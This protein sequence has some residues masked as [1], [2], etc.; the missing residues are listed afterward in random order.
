MDSIGV[1]YCLIDNPPSPPWGKETTNC[2]FPRVTLPIIKKIRIKERYKSLIILSLLHVWQWQKVNNVVSLPHPI[3]ECPLFFFFFFLVVGGGG[4]ENRGLKVT[5]WQ[6]SRHPPNSINSVWQ[7][8]PEERWTINGVKLLEVCAEESNGDRG[9]TKWRRRRWRWR[10]RLGWGRGSRCSSFN[11]GEC[12]GR[13]CRRR[14]VEREKGE[15]LVLIDI[16]RDCNE[17]GEGMAP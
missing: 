12:A 17:C 8:G 6:G 4:G 2:P 7:L 13:G 16:D 14:K 1:T 10:C 15:R 5:V 9:L 3:K 11:G